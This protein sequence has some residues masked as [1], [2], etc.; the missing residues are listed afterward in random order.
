MRTLLQIYEIH[1]N[2]CE[3]ARPNRTRKLYSWKKKKSLKAYLA[4]GCDRI[5]CALVNSVCKD[6][7][8]LKVPSFILFLRI[9]KK[10]QGGTWKLPDREGGLSCFGATESDVDVS[11]TCWY[12]LVFTVDLSDPVYV[13]FTKRN[14]CSIIK[15]RHSTRKIW[16]HCIVSKWPG[17][18]SSCSIF[19]PLSK[20]VGPF[21]EV[22]WYELMIGR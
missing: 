13:Y 11:Q 5:A 22:L 18:I 10:S 2:T 9:P 7:L 20:T 19:G 15:L 16:T 21:W 3:P 1:R 6:R 12:S 8:E 4:Q 17:S 14:K